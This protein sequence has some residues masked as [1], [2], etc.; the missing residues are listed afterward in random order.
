MKSKS[1]HMPQK[2]AKIIVK[3][4]K[5]GKLYIEPSDLFALDSVQELIKRVVQS[6]V[7]NATRRVAIK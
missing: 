5:E 1:L 2:Q 4:T 6:K 3:S 7:L